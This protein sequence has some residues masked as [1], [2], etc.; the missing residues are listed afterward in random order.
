MK[1]Y[2]QCPHRVTHGVT[3]YMHLPQKQGA[4]GHDHQ[5]SVSHR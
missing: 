2:S 3:D 5:Y 1:R 4:F